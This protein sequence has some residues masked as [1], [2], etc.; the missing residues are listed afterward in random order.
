MPKFKTKLT[1]YLEDKKLRPIVREA[2]KP[3]SLRYIARKYDLSVYGVKRL[4]KYHQT[5]GK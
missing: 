5:K 4:L 2:Q 3:V 1:P